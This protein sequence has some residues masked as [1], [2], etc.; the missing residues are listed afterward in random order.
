M[1]ADAADDAGESDDEETGMDIDGENSDEG[2]DALDGDS[3]ESG[4]E[5][6]GDSEMEGSD[7]DDSDDGAGGLEAQHAAL[8]VRRCKS[9]GG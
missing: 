4:D 9:R 5:S 3:D 8:Q 2:S 1:Q 6:D 7:D